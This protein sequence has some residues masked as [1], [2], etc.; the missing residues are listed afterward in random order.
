MNNTP[1]TLVVSRSYSSCA[2]CR[3]QTLPSATIHDIISGWGGGDPG[4]GARFTAI[5]SDYG[6]ADGMDAYMRAILA[7]MRP[8]LPIVEYDDAMAQLRRDGNAN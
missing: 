8:D 3:Q 5:T 7:E 1:T 6:S 4:C 2:A